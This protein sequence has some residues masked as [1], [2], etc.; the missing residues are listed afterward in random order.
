M[1]MSN[2]LNAVRRQITDF[3]KKTSKKQKIFFVI[4]AVAAI[5]VIVVLSAVLGREEY[6]VLYSGMNEAEAG[7]VMSMLGDMGVEARAQGPGTILVPAGNADE[8]RMRLASEGYP[9]SGLNYDIFAGSTSLGTTD[10][11][12]QTYLQY[13]LQ[14]N[15][16]AT[17]MKL[18]RVEDCVVIINMPSESLFVLSSDEKE[19]SASVMLKVKGGGTLKDEEV[20]AISHLVLKSVSG[21]KP[22]NISIVDSSMTLYDVT[23]ESREE[24]TTTQYELTQL[25]KDTYKQQVLSVLTPVFGEENVSATVNVVLNFDQQTVSAVEFKP[26]N[27]NSDE[28]L[29]VSLEELYEKTRGEGSAEGVAGTDSNGVGV[30][31]YVIDDSNIDEFET[32]SRTV[33]YELNELQTQIVKQQGTIEK[34]SVAVLLNS[35]FGDEDYS[36][37]VTN[38]V[39]QAIGVDKQFISVESLP[40]FTKAGD[41]TTDVFQE[42]ASLIGSL[43]NKELI[44]TLI[45]AAAVVLICL[46]ILKFVYSFFRP[47]ERIAALAGGNADGS[48]NDGSD[49]QQELA[50]IALTSKN[51]NIE[52]I[53]KFVDRDPAAAAQLLRNWLLENDI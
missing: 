10:L 39:S 11:Q 27:Q 20:K 36:E 50:E 16:R 17:I 3:L 46:F 23:G 12:T 38:L 24:Y 45:I 44:K 1:V 43:K 51:K 21:L 26:P 53:E 5:A 42:R 52:K 41:D 19:A 34:L 49:I 15:L 14:E 22:E 25:T 29:A 48:L 4:G 30:P 32:I 2:F 33:N 8:L 6:V 9:K 31:E 13:Q 7:E 35:G 18:D 28:G 37:S 47:R 40:F